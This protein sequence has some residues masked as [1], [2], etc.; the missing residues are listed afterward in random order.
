[1]TKINTLDKRKYSRDISWQTAGNFGAQILGI[2]AM[3]LLTRAYSP[4]DFA[5]FNLFSQIVAALSII[6][7]LRLEYFV[8]LPKHFDEAINM[9]SWLGLRGLLF[10]IPCSLLLWIGDESI[11]KLLGDPGIANWLPL[12]VL[13]AWL[14]S[15][16]VAT[17]QLV[18]RYGG[19]NKTAIAEVLNR[20]G[21]VST[22]L[23]GSMLTPN[24]VG[25]ISATAAGLIVKI[26]WLTHSSRHLGQRLSFK[27]GA[28]ISFSFRKTASALSLAN[29]I[30]TTSGIIP[31]IF[32][33]HQ[34]GKDSMGNYGL[35][36]TTLYLP[37]ALLAQAIGNVYYQR[38]SVAFTTREAITPLFMYTL[39]RLAA[40]ALPL[41]ILIAA[42]APWFYPFIFGEKWESA[43]NIAQTLSISACA[44]FISTPLERTCLIVGIWWYPPMWHLLRAVTT[45]GIV[46]IAYLN[47][48]DLILFIVALGI[49]AL[50]IY[51]LDIYANRKF[52]NLS[53]RE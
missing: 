44:S 45:F 38:A 1:M 23:A 7:T 48:L 8:M 51:S 21:Y 52:S 10:A 47:R 43:G 24:L 30:S 15:M 49:Q 46:A 12:A 42:L 53:K 36:I 2:A 17:Q 40:I 39:R 3:P 6:L 34:Y 14:T 5:T 25:L 31:L 16:A 32:I 37:S 22:A 11:A 9:T 4:Q 35:V 33:G 26:A 27:S 20:G 19:F 41:Y 18:Q 29:I 50:L 28:H 13:T